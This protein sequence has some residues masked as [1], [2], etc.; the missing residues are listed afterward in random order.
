MVRLPG[1]IR[2]GV[3]Y[4]R[5]VRLLPFVLGI[6]FFF[7]CP[8]R[9]HW[10]VVLNRSQAFGELFYFCSI[11]TGE[12]PLRQ[13][14]CFQAPLFTR[15]QWMQAASR[16]VTYTGTCRTQPR[17]PLAILD[18]SCALPPPNGEISI[19][20]Y[21]ITTRTPHSSD[22]AVGPRR[23]DAPRAS[24]LSLAISRSYCQGECGAV[25][26]AC[27]PSHQVIYPGSGSI[28][29]AGTPAGLRLRPL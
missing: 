13:V 14:A 11:S 1:T 24:R 29:G 9:G 22:C 15:D 26:A 12:S 17:S 5:Q 21:S 2:N 7:L 28:S 25:R 27:S 10:R 3:R 23:D 20:D 4:P 8:F 16:V 6:P 18:P 19:W